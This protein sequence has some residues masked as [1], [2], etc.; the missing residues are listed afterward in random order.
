MTAPTPRVELTLSP[1][2]LARA[3]GADTVLSPG[4]PLAAVSTDSRNVAPGTIFFALPGERVDG[5]TFLPQVLEAKAAA[6]VVAKDRVSSLG[7]EAFRQK[8]CGVFAVKD[9]LLALQA[10]ATWHRASQT[11]RVVGITGSVGK[12]TTKEFV[13]AALAAYV[14]EDAVLKTEGNL[15]SQ[16]GL[17]LM[18]LQLKPS[19]KYAVLEM[20]MSF[21]GEL[22][23]LSHIARPDVATITAIAAAHVENL[24]SIE[25]VARAKAEIFDG[26]APD[27]VAVLPEWDERVAKLGKSLPGRVFQVGSS[28]HADMHIFADPERHSLHVKTGSDNYPVRV[29]LLG[30]H[31]LRNAGLALACAVAATR[32]AGVQEAIRGI[33]NT[34]VPGGRSRL[35]SDIRGLSVLDDSY[36]ANPASVAA[37][38]DSLPLLPGKRSVAILGDMLELGPNSR[39]DHREAGRRAAAAGIDLLLAFG[40]EA[41]GYVEGAKEAGIKEAHHLGSDFDKAAEAVCS[42]LEEGDRVLI[43]GSRGMRMERFLQKMQSDFGKGYEA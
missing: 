34:R 41:E 22:S 25:G 38:L 16:I 21:F 14:G 33:E 10:L 1:E 29:P 11:A 24:G 15:N 18:V 35:V 26:L 3:T 20:G 19:H 7:L 37:A 9:T 30:L 39:E 6:V 28:P 12:T 40:E 5:H 42:L 27:G 2:D 17:P 4:A 8:G 13:A 23:R 36:N 32:G 31:N 43:K